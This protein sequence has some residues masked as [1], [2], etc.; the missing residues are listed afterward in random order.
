[1]L[2]TDPFASF[3]AVAAEPQKNLINPTQNNNN[4]NNV[5]VEENDHDRHLAAVAYASRAHRRI[6]QEASMLVAAATLAVAAHENEHDD[7][8]LDSTQKDGSPR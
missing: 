4:D 6:S 7:S 3:T 1:M 2:S 8:G 5:Q